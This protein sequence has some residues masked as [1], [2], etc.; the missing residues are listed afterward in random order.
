MSTATCAKRH[1][2]RVLFVSVI[3]AIKSFFV[4][5]LA[6]PGFRLVGRNDNALNKNGSI[7][8]AVII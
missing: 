7:A 4:I 2:Y 5:Q 1:G 3:L 8:G 6:L